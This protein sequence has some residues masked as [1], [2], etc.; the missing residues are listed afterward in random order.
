MQKLIKSLVESFGPSGKEEQVREIVRMEIASYVD[1]LSDSPLGSLHAIVN[2]VG[3]TKVMVAAHMDEIGV[4][5]SHI[6]KNGVARFHNIGGVFP[7]TL[8]GH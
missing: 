3:G 5:I 7:H 8:V 1:E 2:P 6:D 4:I